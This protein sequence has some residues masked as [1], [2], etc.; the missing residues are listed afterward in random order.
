V[1]FHFDNDIMIKSD[2]PVAPYIFTGIHYLKFDPYGDLK[3]KNGTP[4]YYWSDGSIRDLPENNNNTFTSLF[5]IRDYT[6]ET[7]LNDASNYKRSTF[8]L[9]VGFGIKL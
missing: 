3:D 2:Y 9:P 5:L 8:V 1:S 7:K 4:Y 6:Y